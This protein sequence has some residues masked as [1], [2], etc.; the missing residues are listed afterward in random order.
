MNTIQTQLN[1]Y[2]RPTAHFDKKQEAVSS[3]FSSPLNGGIGW[4]GGTEL[5]SS[6]SLAVAIGTDIY[7]C[8]RGAGYVHGHHTHLTPLCE[9]FN[10]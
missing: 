6:A 4:R 1:L 5:I 3:P 2:L 8:I 7:A 9:C 10:G